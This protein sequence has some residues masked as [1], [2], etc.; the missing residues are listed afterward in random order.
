MTKKLLLTAAALGAMAFAGA[1][2][3]GVLSS[4]SEIAGVQVSAAIPAAGGAPAVPAEVYLIASEY[5]FPASGL[6]TDYAGNPAAIPAIPARANTFQFSDLTNEINVANGASGLTF[7]VTYELTGPAKFENV[8]NA[9]VRL[10]ALTGTVTPVLSNGGKTLK[11]FVTVSNTTGAPVTID[12]VTLE[13]FDLAVTG[14]EA[15][16]VSYAL[17]QVIAGQNVDLDSSNAATIVGF[18]SV[19]DDLFKASTGSVLAALNDFETFKTSG[20]TN[21]TVAAGGV[22]ATTTTWSTTTNSVFIDLKATGTGLLSGIIT[23]AE[24]TLTGPQ[25]EALDATVGAAALPADAT[26]TSAKYVLAAGDLGANL[27]L[28]TAADTAI[29]AGTYAAV[30][31]PTYGTNWS[32]PT[33]IDRTLLRVGLDGTNFYAP[34]F[35]LDNGAANSSLRIA[36]NGSAAI[37]PIVVSLKANNGSAAPT[38]TYT[39]PS[40]AAGAFVSVRGDQLKTAFGTS[41]ANGDLLITVQSQA[42]GLSAKVRTTQS[43]GQ[44]YENS[45]GIT[46]PVN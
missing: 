11:A 37:G 15:V 16:K 10:G 7:V 26:A 34:W 18:S 6:K 36:N 38:G 2:S 25:V 44:V 19:F 17:Q 4:N 21:V 9:A 8:S 13:D 31:K 12:A 3:A 5:T 22:S 45:L 28:T 23:G 14:K 42:N 39:I 1:A 24:V 30:I 40:V 33:T 27:K 32:G 43:T 35:A 41:A 20:A 29:A 46:P